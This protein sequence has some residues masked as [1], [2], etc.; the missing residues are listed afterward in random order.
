M[1]RLVDLVVDDRF[2]FDGAVLTVIE[3]AQDIWGVAEVW[4]Q[5]LDFP[6][7]GSSSMSVVQL[8]QDTDIDAP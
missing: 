7:M 4:V 8:I 1:V 6:L 2:V 5:E 3:P